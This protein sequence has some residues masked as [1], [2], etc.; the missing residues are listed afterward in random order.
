MLVVTTVS[1]DGG[2]YFR[3][4]FE[5]IS[6]SDVRNPLSSASHR[7]ESA[8]KPKAPWMKDIR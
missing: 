1:V 5:V 6:G 8:G 3:T 7:V 4:S 2:G